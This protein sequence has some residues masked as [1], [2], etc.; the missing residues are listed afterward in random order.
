MPAVRSS[1][2]DV[3]WLTLVGFERVPSGNPPGSK[4]DSRRTN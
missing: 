1:A 3:G 4:S 2:V